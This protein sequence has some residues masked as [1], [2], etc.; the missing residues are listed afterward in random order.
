MNFVSSV[1]LA[2][3]GIGLTELV[4]PELGFGAEVLEPVIE[5][6]FVIEA[7]RLGVDEVHFADESRHITGATKVVGDGFVLEGPWR[8]VVPGVVVVGV[9]AGE[10]R[11]AR[12]DA[13]RI[14]AVGG[15]EAG[16]ERASASRLGV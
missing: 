14:G 11:G 8:A 1:R 4:G 3:A 12:G 9:E 10:E 13:D 5:I 2:G 7:M 15:I 16:T 6:D